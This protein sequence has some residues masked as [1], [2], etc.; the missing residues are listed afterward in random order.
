MKRGDFVVPPNTKVRLRDYDPGFT[1]SYATEKDASTKLEKHIA[2]LAKLQNVLYADNTRALLVVLQ[3]M[4]AAGKDGTIRHVMSG[5]N[6]QGAVVHSFKSPSSEELSHDFLWRC[7]RAMPARG[8]IGIFNRSHYEEVLVVRVHPEILNLQHLPPSEKK[9]KNF[10]KHRFEAINDFERYLTRNGITVLKFFLHLSKE[11]QRRR[12]LARIDT[13][14]KNWKFSLADAKERGY[15]DKYTSA[16]EE[17]LTH[18]STE[19]APWRVIP[20][21]N[22]W[23]THLAVA[24]AM[25]NTLEALNLKYPITSEEHRQQL[26]KS[27][28]AL[29]NEAG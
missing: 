1:G 24:E 13:P 3:A 15:W 6:P 7:A 26:L 4:D 9:G 12:F 10:W 17:A 2:Q 21:D 27:K 29:E 28:E 14:D 25:I 8:M 11:E 19:W 18:T 22:K 16:Y 23:F 5:V 20:A